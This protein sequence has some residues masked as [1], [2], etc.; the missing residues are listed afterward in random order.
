MIKIFRNDIR[1][2]IGWRA[3]IKLSLV[4]KFNFGLLLPPDFKAAN[5][6]S[7]KAFIFA[8][9]S[10]YVVLSYF[11]KTLLFFLYQS[12]CILKFASFVKVNFNNKSI[13][14]IGFD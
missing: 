6:N 1:Q 9:E 5:N 11:K 8:E 14:S 3:L 13:T 10:K 12:R 4:F 2:T 7:L